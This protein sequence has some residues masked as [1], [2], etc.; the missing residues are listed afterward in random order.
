MNERNTRGIVIDASH[1]CM[2]KCHKC[3]RAWYVKNRQKV[4]GND[5]T[6]DQF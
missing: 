6:V 4:P 5:L 2:L 3:E 1:K